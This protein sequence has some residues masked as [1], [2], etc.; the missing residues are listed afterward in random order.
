MHLLVLLL[1]FSP[2]FS[3][4]QEVLYA[5]QSAKDKDSLAFVKRSDRNRI[6]LYVSD[7]CLSCLSS[8]ERIKPDLIKN[9]VVVVV[10]TNN[11]NYLKNLVK[12]NSPRMAGFVFF[13]PGKRLQNDLNLKGIPFSYIKFDNGSFKKADSNRSVL[14]PPPSIYR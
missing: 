11:L 3:K 12:K 9:R 5:F 4:A 10:S 13:D 8:L 1:L 7:S 6:V 2:S 14:T